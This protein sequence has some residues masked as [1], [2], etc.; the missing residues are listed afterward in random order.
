MRRPSPP[1]P[2]APRAAKSPLAVDREAHASETSSRERDQTREAVPSP[3]ASAVPSPSACAGEPATSSLLNTCHYSF[4]DLFRAAH[5]T[6]GIGG[7]GVGGDGEE[8]AAVQ[9]LYAMSQ[10][11]RNALVKAWADS[12]GWF[13]EEQV[14]HDGA[15]AFTAFSPERRVPVCADFGC[16]GTGSLASGIG[17]IGGIGDR[18]APTEC[19][20]VVAQWTSN[21]QCPRCGEAA[22]RTRVQVPHGG[23]VLDF[24]RL[25]AAA[26][27]VGDDGDDGDDGGN[28]SNGFVNKV[29]FL[30]MNDDMDSLEM[31]PALVVDG[32]V[33]VTLVGAAHP[34]ITDCDDNTGK[35]TASDGNNDDENSESEGGEE[36]GDEEV[37]RGT[38]AVAAA[39]AAAAPREKEG[40]AKNQKPPTL[41]DKNAAKDLS[42]V[43]DGFLYA[44]GQQ[45]AGSRRALTE[46]GITHVLNCCDRIKCR[47]KKSFTYKVLHVHDTKGTDITAQFDEALQ[48]LDACEEAGGRALVH[49]LVGASRSVSICLAY[50]VKRRKIPLDAAFKQ[51]RERRSVARPN[52]RFCEQL[53]EYEAEVRGGERSAM[54]LEGTH[55]SEWGRWLVRLV[56]LCVWA[57]V[58]VADCAQSLEWCVRG[59]TAVCV[60][61]GR[62]R[63]LLIL[64]IEDEMTLHTKQLLLCNTNRSSCPLLSTVLHASL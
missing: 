54:T 42:C 17:G 37:R 4:R 6:N 63:S 33:R 8:E 55:G 10:G 21:Y 64:S 24:R 49:C 41:A 58:H 28:G 39:A 50:M 30:D 32:T 18:A 27:G 61:V 20:D 38:A 23:T 59:Y 45:A 1:S 26:L 35:A 11:E 29:G 46:A 2:T 7:D 3:T 9:A 57:I 12:A 53:I 40:S 48:F 25:C 31:T 47:F 13:T 36:K 15:T 22:G 43:V 5:R 51:C 34:R 60:C 14:G 52:R 62:E 19:F 44:G 16:R 56:R